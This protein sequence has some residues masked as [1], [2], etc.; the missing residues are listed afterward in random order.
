MAKRNRVSNQTAV[1]TL[2][3]VEKRTG[4]FEITVRDDD[5]NIVYERSIDLAVKTGNVEDGPVP[6]TFDFVPSL[7]TLLKYLGADLSEDQETF[8]QEALKGSEKTGEAVAKLLK[9][10][11]DA[12]EATA[13]RNAYSAL[14]QSK[15]PRDVES[16][17]NT[18][19]GM[20]RGMVANTPGSTV[21]SCI[22]TLKTALPNFPQDFTV[23]TYNAAKLPGR[24]SGS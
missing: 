19:A 2:P 24:K 13:Q 22:D 18:W 8:L 17:T 3:E 1:E 6:F 15:K 4:T 7:A 9:G 10:F 5:K 23:A 21:Q 16:I 11:N 12:T 20:I 14:Y